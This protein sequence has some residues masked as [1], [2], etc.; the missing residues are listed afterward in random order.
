MEYGLINVTEIGKRSCSSSMRKASVKP[1]TACLLAQYIPCKGTA[2]SDKMLP[3][4][5]RAPPW[6]RYGTAIRLSLIHI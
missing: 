4:L 1:F 2:L 6:R 3:M 5:I